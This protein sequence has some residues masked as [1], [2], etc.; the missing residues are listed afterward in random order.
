MEQQ[1][2]KNVALMERQRNQGCGGTYAQK[3]LIP[4][5]GSPPKKG[6]GKK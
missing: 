2:K 6:L 1:P 3:I 4:L 5:A